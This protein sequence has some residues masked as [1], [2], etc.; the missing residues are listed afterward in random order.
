MRNT[1]LWA[2]LGVRVSLCFQSASRAIQT[3]EAV[4]RCKVMK[5]SGCRRDLCFKFS[6]PQLGATSPGA[7]MDAASSTTSAWL[8][9]REPS[10]ELRALGS[11]TI[12]VGVSLMSTGGADEC[13]V[14]NGGRSPNESGVAWIERS[15]PRSRLRLGSTRFGKA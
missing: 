15:T 11:D 13:G 5:V 8:G 1:D 9:R 7:A 2:D 6:P 4:R 10:A 3:V 12:P 14:C